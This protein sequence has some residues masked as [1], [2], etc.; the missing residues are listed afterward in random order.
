MLRGLTGLNLSR[1]SLPGGAQESETE[2]P[3]RV[4]QGSLTTRLLHLCH[5]RTGRY[6]T[7]H[8]EKGADGDDQDDRGPEV[9]DTGAV[10]ASLLGVGDRAAGIWDCLR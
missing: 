10:C 3:W 2:E 6:E 5:D 7:E 8:I 1:L 9:L 4:L